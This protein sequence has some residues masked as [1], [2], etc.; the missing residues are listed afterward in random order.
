MAA[1]KRGVQTALF[2]LGRVPSW[3][4]TDNSTSATHKLD[5]GK[6]DFNDEYRKFIEHFG[7]K[8]RTIEVG[9]SNQNGDVEALNGAL[10]RR[11]VQHLLLRGSNDFDSLETYEKWLQAV[12]EQAN[13]LR[14]KRIVE[15]LAVMKPLVVERL[16]EH[17]EEDVLVTGWSTIRVKNNT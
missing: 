7:M 4:Q 15:E 1:I 8:P 16:K 9:K 11:L 5:D 10:K 3:H 14:Q 6:R 17:S 2:Q 13:A 12:V